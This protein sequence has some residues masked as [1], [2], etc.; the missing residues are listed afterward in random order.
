MADSCPSCGKRFVGSYTL[1]QCLCCSGCGLQLFI[2]KSD[3]AVHL[4]SQEYISTGMV[5]CPHCRKQVYFPSYVGEIIVTCSSCS[6]RFR[7]KQAGEGS[8]AGREP[9]IH[10]VVEALE[11]PPPPQCT[12]ESRTNTGDRPIESLKTVGIILGMIL[13]PI[14]YPV[15]CGSSLFRMGRFGGPVPQ[16]PWDFA[17]CDR[18]AGDDDTGGQPAAKRADLACRIG[19]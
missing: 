6:G 18:P 10:V 8:P 3:M 19:A 13:L 5:A 11:P 1:G 16:T 14:W 17:L 12:R 7:L 9:A 15:Y 2:D 4:D